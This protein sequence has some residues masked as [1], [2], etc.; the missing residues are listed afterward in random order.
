MACTFS[1]CGEK[2]ELVSVLCFNIV[3]SMVVFQDWFE[4]IWQTV[5]FKF[6][7]EFEA[8]NIKYI[9]YLQHFQF[10]EYWFS[11]SIEC[12]V[13]HNSHGTF[14]KFENP[15][16][17]SISPSKAFFNFI[18][19]LPLGKVSMYRT[20]IFFS[21]MLNSVKRLHLHDC[22]ICIYISVA[23]IRQPVVGIFISYI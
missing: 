12:S 7:P 20:S 5:V 11:V 15:I 1:K 16:P 10:L 4:K 22:C 9:F 8:L 14:L 3:K 13:W 21:V 2:M 19:S 23:D 17:I 18:P 6:E